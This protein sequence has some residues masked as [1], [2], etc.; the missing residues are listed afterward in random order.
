VN[1]VSRSLIKNPAGV[2]RSGRTKVI[3]RAYCV[4]HSPT[5]LAVVPAR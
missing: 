5:G 3:F 1:L 4:S 2:S